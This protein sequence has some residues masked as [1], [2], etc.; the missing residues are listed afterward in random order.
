MG[1][2]FFVCSNVFAPLRSSQANVSCFF[3][4]RIF[5]SVEKTPTSLGGE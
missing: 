1:I 2:S 5:I 3:S 4:F